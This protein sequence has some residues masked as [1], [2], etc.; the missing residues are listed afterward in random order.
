M[1][2]D[3]QH[4]GQKESAFGIYPVYVC[5]TYIH[6]FLGVHTCRVLEFLGGLIL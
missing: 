4:E 1:Y 3:L 6:V 5:D 2:C